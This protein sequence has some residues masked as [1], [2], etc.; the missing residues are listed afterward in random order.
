[1]PTDDELRRDCEAHAHRSDG[2]WWIMS[3]LL[4]RLASLT[5]RA[6]RA[7]RE[8]EAAVR[9]IGVVCVELADAGFPRGDRTV[10]LQS[11]RSLLASRPSPE[12]PQ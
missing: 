2:H 10:A 8:R 4:D 6:A 11:I 3:A 1:M 7:E 12:T 5:D 9:W